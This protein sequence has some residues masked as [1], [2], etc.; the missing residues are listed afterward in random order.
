MW[1][2][3]G[4]LGNEWTDPKAIPGAAKATVVVAHPP[5]SSCRRGNIG[6]KSAM[7]EEQSFCA[8][9]TLSTDFNRGCKSRGVGLLRLIGGISVIEFNYFTFLSGLVAHSDAILFS[10]ASTQSSALR[11]LTCWI[12]S[13]QMP[14]DKC[15]AVY[16]TG[17]CLPKLLHKEGD[18]LFQQTELNTLGNDS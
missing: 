17:P 6:R 4:A 2:G 16:H 13:F 1:M 3:A 14:F 8:T 15:C 9:G 18:I 7:K 11:L 5:V 12:S 10:G